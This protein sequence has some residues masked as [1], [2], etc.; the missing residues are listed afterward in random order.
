[1]KNESI[2]DYNHL[3]AVGC[4]PGAGHG[5]RSC[6]RRARSYRFPDS[7]RMACSTTY[8]R[9][10]WLRTS[11]FTECC[12]VAAARHA[13]ALAFAGRGR[14]HTRNGSTSDPSEWPL[15]E[16]GLQRNTYQSARLM[17]T[18]IDAAAGY[19]CRE[20]SMTNK[21]ISANQTEPDQTKSAFFGVQT[22]SPD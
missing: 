22:I 17:L 6:C 21:I 18:C 14:I 3:S 1:M 5:E 19:R 20:H 16:A 2:S 13:P 9:P 7:L 4:Q 12:S 11:V 8:R 10:G 15:L